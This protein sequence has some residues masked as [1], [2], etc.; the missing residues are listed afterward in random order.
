MRQLLAGVMLSLGLVSVLHAAQITVQWDYPWTLPSSAMHVVGVDSEETGAGEPGQGTRAIDGQVTTFWHTQWVAA[1]PPHPH[2]IILDLGQILPVVALSQLPRQDNQLNGSITQY[3]WSVSLDQATWGAPVAEGTWPYDA[4]RKTTTIPTTSG[5]YVRL[6]ALATG[7]GKPF[8]SVA[9]IGVQ[10][11]LT[12]HTMPPSQ[13]GF[14]QV[15]RCDAPSATQSCT[16]ATAL[17]GAKITAW[18][19]R[20]TDSTVVV[21]HSYCY[22]V[23]A[24]D[25]EGQQSPPGE[26]ANGQEQACRTVQ[27]STTPPAPINL[28]LT[29]E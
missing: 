11:L 13:G 4:T 6:Q 3:A 28:S 10:Y 8:T 5:R 20:Y 27:E 24:V 1:Q 25:K 18:P 15:Y 23:F 21:G 14:F 26:T 7:A 22:T 17:P 12:E 9:E 19:L 16:P 2:W 29:E